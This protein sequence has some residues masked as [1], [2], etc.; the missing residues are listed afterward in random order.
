MKYKHLETKNEYKSCYTS[1]LFKWSMV[2]LSAISFRKFVRSKK[3][4]V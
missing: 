1:K 2:I 3:K 4:Y